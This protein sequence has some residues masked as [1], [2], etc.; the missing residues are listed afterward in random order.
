MDDL[1]LITA[2]V[3]NDED[4]IENLRHGIYG[5]ISLPVFS[6]LYPT[7]RWALASVD[8]RHVKIQDLATFVP[9]DFITIA[10]EMWSGWAAA[11]YKA[12]RKATGFFEV[13]IQCGAHIV[14][15]D[16]GYHVR[17][18]DVSYHHMSIYHSSGLVFA[19]RMIQKHPLKILDID[20]PPVSLIQCALDTCPGIIRLEQWEDL[21]PD[22]N[23]VEYA[24]RRQPDLAIHW[25]QYWSLA[26]DLDPHV[27]QY[28]ENPTPELLHKAVQKDPMVL[29]HIPTSYVD[30]TMV[31]EAARKKPEALQWVPPITEEIQDILIHGWKPFPISQIPQNKWTPELRRRCLKLRVN[32]EYLASKH[33]LTT[34]EK[35]QAAKDGLYS[36]PR[37]DCFWPTVVKAVPSIA[38]D[39]GAVYHNPEC[40]KYVA[41]PDYVCRE[42]C[43]RDKRMVAYITDPERAHELM[44]EYVTKPISF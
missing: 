43:D 36:T 28:V 32:V 34:E 3:Q 12:H 2:I 38:Y 31:L 7:T 24:I 14:S 13:Y 37:Y 1:Q 29:R 22:I 39:S 8:D 15:T 9:D 17:L 35:I 44:K 18:S 25:P 21:S 33:L 20:T 41:Q 27:I 23:F 26:V 30:N 6:M 42:A 19:K 5:P 11:D 16:G 4:T 10:G 40:I